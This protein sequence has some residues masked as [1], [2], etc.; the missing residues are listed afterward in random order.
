MSTIPHIFHMPKTSSLCFH[1]SMMF[2]LEPFFHNDKTESKDFQVHVM[3][4]KKTLL[5][6][7]GAGAVY[8]YNLKK[9]AQRNAIIIALEKSV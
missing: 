3:K 2:S 9:M 5:R 6:A 7:G 1:Q 4:L 8:P